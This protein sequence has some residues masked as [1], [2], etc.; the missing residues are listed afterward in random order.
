MKCNFIENLF[1]KYFWTTYYL[2]LKSLLTTSFVFLGNLHLVGLDGARQYET[3]VLEVDAVLLEKLH[4]GISVSAP[5]Q[6]VI[7]QTG[8]LHEPLAVLFD[9]VVPEVAQAH[10]SPQGRARAGLDRPLA[11]PAL[12]KQDIGKVSRVRLKFLRC[13]Q[14][15]CARF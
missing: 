14:D 7:S 4:S 2:L 1:I 6:L 12:L 9:D 11:R 13:H 10:V 8:V 15:C 3:S 5:F